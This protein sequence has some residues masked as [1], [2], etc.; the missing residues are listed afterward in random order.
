MPL[1]LLPPPPLSG[2][3]VPEFEVVYSQA[4]PNPIARCVFSSKQHII[5]LHSLKCAKMVLCQMDPL[6]TFN[7]S[8]SICEIYP[9][10]NM[11]F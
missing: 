4:L 5:L 3:H 9:C 2:N 8:I 1:L 11:F 6:A 7:S 10:W